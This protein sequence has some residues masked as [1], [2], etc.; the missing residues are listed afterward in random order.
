MAKRADSLTFSNATIDLDDDT[1][2][3]YAKE[4]IVVSSLS[5]V[6]KELDKKEGLTI[7][8][9]QQQMCAIG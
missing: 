4:D 2:T 7:I 1:I 5:G 3:E 6:L 8:V 9:K